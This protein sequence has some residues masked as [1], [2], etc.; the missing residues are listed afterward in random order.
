M[1][2][3][4]EMES[5]GGL[6]IPDWSLHWIHALHNLYRFTGDR[7]LVTE[8]LPTAE[9]ILR[10]YAPYQGANGLLKDV[11]EWNLIDWSSVHT[12]DTSAAINASWA[13]G[14]REL[15][16]MAA[17]LGEGATGEWA[18]HR[19][20]RVKAGFEAFW[21]EE[22]GSYVDH[23]VDGEKRRPMSQIPG[24]MAVC[25][26][27]APVDRVKRVVET[28][29]NPDS[30][31]IRTWAGFDRKDAQE[32]MIKQFRGIYE[33]DWDVEREIVSAE[34]FMSYVVHDAVAAAGLASK[35]PA[36]YKRWLPFLEGG[37]DTIGE[38]WNWGTHVH[39]WSCTPV[40]DLVFYTLGVTPAEPGY[41]KARIAPRL[42][43]LQRAEGTVPTPHGLIHVRA[44]KDS[45]TV[46]SPVPVIV[47]AE[48]REA[49]ELPAGSHT[50]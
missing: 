20:E 15:M 28:I 17:W 47:D 9:R 2:V 46:D 42:G 33:A 24:A 38:C 30:L 25:A 3:V 31:V 39:G 41:A 35:L 23:I 7:E 19:Y 40:K 29:T 34:P 8:L 36:L 50:V 48:G 43:P 27:I 11:P 1:S 6:T 5:G 49:R 16:E 26:G 13:R 12:E 22:R 18:R 32:R 4:G 10:W 45:V 44:T 21:D 37:Y 14:L